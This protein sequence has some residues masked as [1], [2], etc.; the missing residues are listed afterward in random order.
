MLNFLY[1]RW[2]VFSEII[3]IFMF[4]RLVLVSMERCSIC[5]DISLGFNEMEIKHFLDVAPHARVR[6]DLR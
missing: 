4:G 5:S 1:M 3:F 2:M 6:S